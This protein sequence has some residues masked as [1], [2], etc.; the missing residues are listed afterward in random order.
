MIRFMFCLFL[1]MRLAH[2]TCEQFK[3]LTM[4]RKGWQ[5]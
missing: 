4:E 5:K 3:L 1:E 2:K